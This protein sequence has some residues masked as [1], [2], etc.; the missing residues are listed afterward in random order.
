VALKILT[1]GIR[2]DRRPLKMLQQY[3]WM[4]SYTIVNWRSTGSAWV[5]HCMVFLSEGSIGIA[6]PE[7]C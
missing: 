1:N 3:F 7:I 4:S 2:V 5:S 6:P